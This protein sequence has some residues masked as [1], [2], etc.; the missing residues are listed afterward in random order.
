MKRFMKGFMA[1]AF[2]LLALTIDVP[3]EPVAA[4]S[5]FPSG[6]IANT[7]F[8]S[9]PAVGKDYLIAVNRMASWPKQANANGYDAADENH[10]H[11]YRTASCDGCHGGEH[12][13]PD[14]T[15]TFKYND[16]DPAFANIPEYRYRSYRY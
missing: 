4:G 16:D 11:I 12:Q 8:I 5:E 10:K 6:A 1:S 15:V 3:A 9:V 2:L 7:D 13:E 14:N